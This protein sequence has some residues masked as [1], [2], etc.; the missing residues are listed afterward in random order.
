MKVGLG[1]GDGVC[2]EEKER[3]GVFEELADWLALADEDGESDRVEDKVRE[4]DRVEDEV[5]ENERVED[6]VRE[7]EI[8]LEVE[9]SSWA[10]L[11]VPSDDDMGESSSWAVLPVPSDDDMASWRVGAWTVTMFA[12]PESSCGVFMIG[13]TVL[14]WIVAKATP[15]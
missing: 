4:N 11:P 15:P 10:V 1:D 2:D 5:W 7:N 6:G 8:E 9:S 12:W 13:W 3:V 14:W